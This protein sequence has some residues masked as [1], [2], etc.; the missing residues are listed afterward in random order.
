MINCLTE[1][2]VSPIE[3]GKEALVVEPFL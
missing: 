1:F 3:M 2:Q